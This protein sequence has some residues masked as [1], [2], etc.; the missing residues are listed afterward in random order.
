VLRKGAGMFTIWANLPLRIILSDFSTFWYNKIVMAKLNSKSKH[1]LAGGP[2]LL[3]TVVKKYKLSTTSVK[4]DLNYWL[5]KSPDERISA[6]EILRRQ[7][8][9]TSTPRLRRIARITKRAKG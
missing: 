9:A 3:K 5:S 6:V 7:H 1:Q 4:D 8:Y 2:R